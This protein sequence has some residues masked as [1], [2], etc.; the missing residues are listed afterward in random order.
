MAK[1]YL[2]NINRKHREKMNE[3]K[4]DHS[5][6]GDHTNRRHGAYRLR[7]SCSRCLMVS[8][9]MPNLVSILIVDGKSD[10]IARA[11]KDKA[12]RDSLYEK[13]AIE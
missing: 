10:D 7:Q 5:D 6:V 1:I 2:Y 8:G 3:E 4:T 13:Y 11:A 12:Y 9:K